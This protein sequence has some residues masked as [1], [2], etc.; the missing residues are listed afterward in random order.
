MNNMAYRIS[1]MFDGNQARINREDSDKC[2]TN[3]YGDWL[4]PFRHFA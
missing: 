1:N 2:E 4:M 3:F